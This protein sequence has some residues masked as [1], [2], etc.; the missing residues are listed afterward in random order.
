MATRKFTEDEMEHLKASP[1]VLDVGPKIV[2]FSAEFK[3]EF[4]G[5]MQTGKTPHEIVACLGIDPDVLGATRISGLRSTIKREACS[6]EGFGDLETSSAKGLK[7]HASPE[8]RVKYLEQQLA[9]KDQEIEFLKKIASLG[10]EG[11]ES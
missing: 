5:L 10:Q 7:K 6:G 1:Y 8:A 9:Y 2:H 4:W 3:A 11:P